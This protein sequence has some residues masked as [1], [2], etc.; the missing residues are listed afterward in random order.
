MTRRSQAMYRALLN[1]VV[2]RAATLYGIDL[3]PRHVSTDFEKAAINAFLDV[4]PQTTVSGCHFHLGQAVLRKVN[5]L[6]LKMTYRSDPEFALHSR[7]LYGM[8]YLPTVDVPAGLESI[9]SSMPTVGTQLLDYFD[10]TYVNGPILRTTTS[11]GNVHRA[12]MFPPSMWNVSERF[13]KALPTTSNHVEAWHRRLQTLIVID[14]PS[15]FT[16]LHKL[17]QEQ[18]HTEVAIRRS[19]NGFRPKRKRRSVTEHTQRLTSLMNELRCGRKN[20]GEFLRGVGHAF[21]REVTVEQEVDVEQ[22]EVAETEPRV[23]DGVDGIETVYQDMMGSDSAGVNGSSVPREEVIEQSA[24]VASIIATDVNMNLDVENGN[25]NASRD[26]GTGRR[27]LRVSGISR[28]RVRLLD[29]VRS[30]AERP[31]LRDLPVRRA[32]ASAASSSITTTTSTPRSSVVTPPTPYKSAA[33]SSTSVT[34]RRNC[35]VCLES[36]ADG[37]VVPCGH[38]AC[39]T[40]LNILMSA[41]VPRGTVSCPVCRTAIRD[42]VRLHFAA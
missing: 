8:A 21:G 41:V 4:F 30:P 42:I 20:I 18:R 23:E 1:L 22:Q 3:E 7:M 24:G 29:A 38:C 17:R 35:P 40:C 34:A 26:A 15:F 10:S 37:A 16:C 32:S 19:D 14:H 6:G 33:A 2:E 12:P 31:R 5:E 28:R 27:N 25:I 13:D 39:I 9:R 11:N 36:E